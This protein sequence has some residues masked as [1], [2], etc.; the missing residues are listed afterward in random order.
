M[1]ADALDTL[2]PGY[3]YE[4]PNSKLSA[5]SA[6]YPPSPT[7][8]GITGPQSVMSAWC[9]GAFDTRRNRLMIHGG[10]HADYAGNEIYV[11]DLSTST[12]SRLW[13]PSANSSIYPVSSVQQETYYDGNPSSVHTYNGLLYLPT[14]D[15]L[16]RG[17]GSLWSGSGGGS[18]ASWMFNITNSTW[19]R[20]ADSTY[21][22][23]S[24]VAAYDPVTGH[25]FGFSDR[26]Q[27]IEYDPSANTWTNRASMGGIYMG[28]DVS[29][30]IDPQARLFVAM[31]NGHVIVYDL[32]SKT[33]RNQT[34]SGGSSIVNARGPGLTYDSTLQRIVG[35]AG[36]TSVYSLNTS[37]WTWTQHTAASGNSVSPSTPTPV[38]VFSRFQ[39]IP[40]KNVYILVNS[41]GTSVYAFKVSA[42]GG[43]TPP[44]ADTT[45]PS[46]SISSPT[47]GS[48]ISGTVT[49]AASASDNVGVVGVQFR[50][51]G[52]PL[53]SEDTSAPFSTSWNSTSSANGSHTLTAVARDA[54][55]NST[56]SAAVSVSV[57]NSSTPPSGGLDL[58]LRTWVGIAAPA[59]D[60]G[61]YSKP[62]EGK[63]ARLLF[64][65]AR[66]RMVLAGG[67]YYGSVANGAGSNEVWTIDLARGSSWTK[68]AGWCGP[69][70]STQPAVPDNV[71]WAYDSLR[72]RGIIF[73]GY[74]FGSTASCSGVTQ[75]TGSALFN[76]GSNR[77]EA[78]A[79]P[80]PSGGYGGDLGSTFAVYDPVTDAVY[81]F[82]NLGGTNTMEILYLSSNT[83]E[84]VRLGT[85]GDVLQNTDPHADQSVIDVAGRSIY[86]ISRPLRALMRYSIPDKKV[87]ET[88]QMPAAWIAPDG[89]DHET[90]MT[91]DSINRVILNPNTHNYDGAVS[92]LA[93]YHVDTKSW[94]W[95]SVPSSVTGNLVG[96]DVRNNAVLFMGRSATDQFWL[97]RYGNGSSAPP[98]PPPPTDTIAPSVSITSP[99]SG[100]TV[101][102]AVSLSASATDNVA[103]VGVQ[104]KVDGIN[105]GAEDTT[106]PYSVSWNSATSSDGAHVVTAVAR[107]A[108]GNS[109]VSS[110]VS[111]TVS[112]GA[113]TVTR[114]VTPA[115]DWCTA[116]NTAAPGTEVVFAQGN[117]GSTCWITARGSASAPIVVR[118]E[119]ASQPAVF[120]Y[121][122]SSSNV[123]ELRDA[124]FLI[125]RGF[126]FSQTQDG[127]DAIRLFRANDV[128]I[129]QN[130]FEKIGGVSIAANTY[131]TSNIAVRRNTFKNLYFTGV[132]FGCHNGAD[133][134][135]TN[136]LFEENLIDGVTTPYEP[137]A[138]GYGVEVKLNSYGMIRDNTVYRTKGPGIMVYGS[139]QGDPASVLVGN[140]VEGSATEG[141]I[142]VGGGPAVVQNNVLVGNA[143]GG[144]SA[145]NYN[146][147][148]LQQ[149]VWIVHNTILNNADSGINVS[150]WSSGSGN[151]IAFNAIS[152]RSGTPALSPSA[153][154][155]TLSGN[156]TCSSPSSCF[157]NGTTPPY[158]LW[159]SA[160]SPL[161]NAAGSGTEAW[162]PTDDFMGVVRGSLPDVGAFEWTAE[163]SS[164]LVG[165][166]GPRPSRVSGSTSPPPPPPTSSP[167]PA[168]TNVRIK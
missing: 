163:S 60:Q 94:E 71:G 28:E 141:G 102:G 104:F 68:L 158:D 109:T 5:Y 75:T 1:A 52:N 70:G 2:Q 59:L 15:K 130:T 162:R 129:E 76:F 37:N 91:F 107:D 106:A 12:W 40:S 14:Q 133:C 18:R 121:S 65:S 134:R 145:Q 126:Y 148:N 61:P 69:S 149:N 27:I 73:P 165:G 164:H 77:W 95:E 87:V 34:T 25:I 160:S 49:I 39:Y 113:T 124:A 154:A 152:P 62:Y 112:N 16:W 138:I 122:G 161:L 23:V 55:G 136:I 35:W 31:G 150:G 117:Y 20:K 50:L 125:I 74:Y 21:L 19:E 13:G 43:T 100:A 151:V 82:R 4:F 132:Y 115:D 54:A 11:F 96:F 58:P 97:Y 33:V 44:P 119:N 90:Y 159:P 167:L 57:S 105:V 84:Q 63:H 64:D 88:I 143:Y 140:Y 168:P 53:G 155:G 146:S 9:G 98:P 48:T 56:T 41:V 99:V 153:P 128:T 142:V 116:V 42:G 80:A 22:G 38:G 103:I 83:W 30:V 120:N 45:A 157:V 3:W 92:G 29:G 26:Y 6:V 46:V 127:V 89:Y 118:S 72:D 147:R 79:N 67:D 101:S 123:I 81:R 139:N 110:V 47:S 108:A 24:Q 66:G 8:P 86:A 111:V 85:N 78:S 131:D 7:P 51:D 17:G 156:I 32:N 10:G 144:I 166:S 135:S 114:R 36:G 93:I 137:G